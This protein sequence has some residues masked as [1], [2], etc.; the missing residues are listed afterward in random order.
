MANKEIDVGQVNIEDIHWLMDILQSIDVGLIVLDRSYKVMAWNSFMENH[1]GVNAT[2]IKD[3][4]LFDVFPSVPREWFRQKAESVFLLKSSNFTV[5]EQRPYLFKFKNYRPI[6]GSAQYMY[7]NITLAPLASVTGEINHIG[8]LIYD[9]TD[10][11]VSKLKLEKANIELESLSET[12]FLTQLNNRGAWEQNLQ[13]EFN[14]SKRSGHNCS[15]VMFDIDHFKNVN[16]CYG[17]PAGD[18]VIKRTAELLRETMRLTD[19][20]GRYG[21]EEFGVILVDTTAEDSMI[22]TERLRKRIEAEVVRYAEDEIQFTVSLGVAELTEDCDDYKLW[23]ERSDKAL[24]VCKES[25][26][27]QSR[28]YL[29][30]D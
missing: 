20:A 18:E 2:L 9:V 10:I 8:V 1:S 7:Q 13:A 17:H 16:D 24:Y 29:H 21:G 30:S 19:I 14:R 22:F 23:L 27:N 25:G 11:A 6:T 26:R 5:W 15:V 4:V 12:D 3:K 28:M